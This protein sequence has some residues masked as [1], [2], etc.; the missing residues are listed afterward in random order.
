[1]KYN[2]QIFTP[3]EI[4]TYVDELRLLEKRI[5]YPLENGQENFHIIHGNN[6]PQFFTQQGFKTRFVA[7]KHGDKVI[8]S[9]AGVWKPVIIESKE[10]TGFYISDLK[11][12]V[13]HRKK[14]ILPRLLWYLFK[15]WPFNSDYQGW[16]FNFFCT[17]LRNGNGVEASFKGLNLTKLPSLSA[18]IKIF[19]IDPVAFQSFNFNSHPKENESSFINLSP[20]RTELVLWNNGIK[21]IQSTK[22]GSILQLG[23]LHPLLFT[24]EFSQRLKECIK[25]IKN[26]KNGLVCFAIDTRDIKKIDWLKSNGIKTNTLC[27][28]FSFSPFAPS[29][30]KS[31]ILYISTGEI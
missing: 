14:K 5:E 13:K 16:D 10:Y 27:N 19:M 21:D 31:N 17:M 9:V 20:Y 30:K 1:M 6:Y 12:D 2:F 4:N 26:R 15:R 23:H 24:K 8:G 3:E 25:E 7:I 28:I 22:D 18:T 29:L 11:I